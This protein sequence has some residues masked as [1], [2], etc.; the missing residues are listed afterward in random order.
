MTNIKERLYIKVNEKY[1]SAFWVFIQA[2]VLFTIGVL[3]LNVTNKYLTLLITYVISG[4]FII[5]GITGI[6][7]NVFSNNSR[8]RLINFLSSIFNIFISILCIF[9]PNI[10]LSIFPILFTA[11]IFIDSI[12]KTVI[13]LI[14][15]ENKLENKYIQILRTVLT[16]TFLIILIF[17]PLF[18]TKVT[19]I[20]V[21]IYFILLANT[22]FLDVVDLLVPAKNKNKIK[23]RIRIV[24]C[25]YSSICS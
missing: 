17:F 4:F 23:K 25:F 8:I 18:R 6:L 19:Y 21:G 13:C 12:I 7:Q 3:I 5:V 14:Y 2:L 20:I 16:Y 9:N 11:Y 1:F 15:I 10:F 22:Y 24:T